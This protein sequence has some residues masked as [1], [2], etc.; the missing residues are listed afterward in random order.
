MSY[1]VV[2]LVSGSGTLL[3]ALVDAREAGEL[4]AELVAVGSDVAD[5]R[6][7]E[8]AAEAGIACFAHPM[9]RLL[10]R[11]SQ[12]RLDWDAQLADLVDAHRPDLVVSAGFMKLFDRPFMDRFAGR[13]INTH[14]ALLPAFPGAHAV[15][16]ALA[17]GAT[18]TGASIFWVND[19]VDTGEL[20]TQQAVPV[21]PEDDED[22]LHQR[23]KVVERR[24]LVDVVNDL[25]VQAAR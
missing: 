3:Q 1:R 25:S 23:I 13:I 20:I 14:P 19:G 11:G 7:L 18:E 6:A 12:E 9:P 8:R 21:H 2:V 22:S 16:D 4:G 15:R 5:C 24:L 10:R 17:A